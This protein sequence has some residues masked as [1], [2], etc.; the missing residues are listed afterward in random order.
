MPS[1]SIKTYNH[2]YAITKQQIETLQK[3]RVVNVRIYRNN[4]FADT[5]VK[6]NRWDNFTA[7]AASFL[8]EYA[9]KTARK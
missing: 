2:N 8:K 5:K 7:M 1:R 3:S 4:G 6:A 9:D